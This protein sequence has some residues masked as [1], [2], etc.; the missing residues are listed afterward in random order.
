MLQ[1][2]SMP[3]SFAGNPDATAAGGTITATGAGNYSFAVN[4]TVPWYSYTVAPT[5]ALDTFGENLD[6]TRF[7]DWLY[8]YPTEGPTIQAVWSAGFVTPAAA[9]P[10]SGTATYTGKTVGLYDE[11]HPCGCL[12]WETLSFQ[13]NMALT[14]DFSG[15]TISGSFTGLRLTGGFVQNGIGSVLPS[16]LNDVSFTAAIDPTRN[17]FTG[18]TGVT[19]HPTG[20]QAFDP[21]ASGSITG[22]FYGPVANEV[23]GV[24]TLSDGIRR[25][26]GSFGG[27]QP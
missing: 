12:E 13:G 20:V 24:W 26:I 27:K 7:G 10:T 2:V 9:V 25:M 23:G 16:T 3:A 17:W 19:N 11:S 15:R 8:Y 18:Q 5:P 22:M 21:G 4:A 6:Y 14:A 1:T